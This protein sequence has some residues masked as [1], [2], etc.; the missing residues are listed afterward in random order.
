[1]PSL[2]LRWRNSRDIVLL[3]L[4]EQM[5]KENEPEVDM[6]AGLGFIKPLHILDGT[7]ISFLKETVS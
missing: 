4:V 6:I 1:M 3:I 7:A 5:P 2:H